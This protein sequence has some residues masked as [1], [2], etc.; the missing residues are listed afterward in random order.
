M[1]SR[2][3]A[4][5]L[6][7]LLAWVLALLPGSARATYVG[8]QDATTLG[9]VAA[10]GGWIVVPQY[11]D[12]Y[13]P[14]TIDGN[15]FSKTTSSLEVARVSGPRFISFRSVAAGDS[16][17]MGPMLAAGAR[18]V[19]AV[20]WTDTAGAGEINSATLNASGNLPD[21]VTQTG[22]PT[23]YS[24][25][26]A[27]GPDGAYAVSWSDGTSTHV[28]A[29]PA[30]AK[31]LTALLGPDVPIDPA[32]QVVLSGGD[33]F[34][35]VDE[36]ADGLSVAPAELGQ[37]RAPPTLALGRAVDVTPLGEGAGGLWAL[38][39][40]NRG[41]FA[42]HVDRS[43]RLSSTPLPAGARDAVIALAGTTAVVAYRAGPH[44]ATYIERLRSKS[45]RHTPI[46][47]T[48]V[49]PRGTACSTPKGIAVD[50][51]SATAYVLTQSRHSMTLT[52]QTTTHKTSSWRRSLTGEVDAVV[53]VGS[54]RVV[55]ESNLPERDVGEQ[56]GGAGPS[57]S[58]AYFFRVFHRA[59]LERTGRLDASVLN[60]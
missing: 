52:T 18:N 31:L 54:N 19:L 13:D 29:A 28:M 46:D 11:E 49:T 48:S 47:R 60:C 56:C 22:R 50:P 36:S 57:Y 12:N 38:A 9:T 17:T 43:G 30:G 6:P 44:C 21:P 25:R 45:S 7:V 5:L 16:V 59:H 10:A 58:Q 32:D 15:P 35:L 1:R 55:V 14:G 27:V 26:L 23:D 8:A 3:R 34:W 33:S 51:A 39:R 20:A 40:G 41:W 24:L 53:A 42:T 37:D 4:L 2:S